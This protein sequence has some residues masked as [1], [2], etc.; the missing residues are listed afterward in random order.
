[1]A[2]AKEKKVPVAKILR[3]LGYDAKVVIEPAESL[4]TKESRSNPRQKNSA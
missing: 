3:E 4:I 1:M 2:I